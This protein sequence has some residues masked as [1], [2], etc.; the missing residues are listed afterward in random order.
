[1]DQKAGGSIVD[2]DIENG[3]ASSSLAASSGSTVSTLTDSCLTEVAPGTFTL[4]ITD[5]TDAL[6]LG[7][8][9]R[10]IKLS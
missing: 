8:D 4:V 5:A 10:I 2:S 3:R 9:I 7:E 6:S 1:M